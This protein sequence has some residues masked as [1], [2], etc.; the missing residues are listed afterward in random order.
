MNTFNLLATLEALMMAEEWIITF[1]NIT[2]LRP[3]FKISRKVQAITYN[4]FK[5]PQDSW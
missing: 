4:F 3:K 1:E 5:K 2:T